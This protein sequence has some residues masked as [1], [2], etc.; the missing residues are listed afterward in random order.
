MRDVMRSRGRWLQAGW[1]FPLALLFLPNCGLDTSGTLAGQD[2]GGG[3]P[4]EIFEE[5]DSPT[6]AVMCDIRKVPVEGSE[7]ATAADIATGIPLTY[8][9]VALA[10]TEGVNNSIGL[11]Y[12]PD[13]LMAC[14]G[15]RRVAFFGSFPEGSHV[16]L[17][18]SQIPTVYPTATAACVAKCVDLVNAD[19]MVPDGGAQSYCEKNATVS[20]NWTQS[21]IGELCTSSGTPKQFTDPRRQQEMVKWVDGLGQFSITTNN[22]TKYN[23]IDGDL[24]NWDTG[25][26]SG[27]VINEGEAWVE[28]Q[29]TENDKSHVLGIATGAG[30][31]TDPSLEDIDFAISLNYNGQ[32]YILEDGDNYV[33]APL[34]SYAPG[35]RFRIKIKDNNDANKTATITYTKLDDPA[36]CA[37]AG[38]K[39]LED[40]IATQ[41]LAS[42]SYP[43]R[44]TA[45]FREPGATLANVTLV[46]IQEK[47]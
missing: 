32:V 20:T 34:M 30:P 10:Q 37:I 44:I 31:D 25:A 1:V 21:C 2:P 4:T 26:A 38:T 24:M 5:G 36:A 35:D 16:C 41:T 46:R 3:Q 42:P 14:G 11:D 33:S 6:G 17:N 29:V 28:F 45:S 23:D 40:E 15:P 47:P 43:L 13:A 8:A 27:Q 19:G 7:C 12:S 9:A 39:C 22:L 18:C